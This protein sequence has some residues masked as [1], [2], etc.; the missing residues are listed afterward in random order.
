MHLDQCIALIVIICSDKN[1]TRRKQ[2][3]HYAVRDYGRTAILMLR[4][5]YQ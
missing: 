3:L 1:Y 2:I 5:K 4:L